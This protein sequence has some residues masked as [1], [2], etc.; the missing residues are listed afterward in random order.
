MPPSSQ[1]APLQFFSDNFLLAAGG[2]LFRLAP[3]VEQ[4]EITPSS[5][6][7]LSSLSSTSTTPT[8]DE[9]IS[10]S[11]L[12][13]P[14][15]NTPPLATLAEYE[16]T[17]AIKRLQICILR[18]STTNY[19]VLPKGRKDVKESLE[20]AAVRETFEESGFPCEL[21]PCPMSTRAPNPD[22][23]VGL[24]PHIEVASEEPFTLTIATQ[25]DGSLKLIFWYLIRVLS[26]SAPKMERTQ[27]PNEDY[28]SMFVDAREGINMLTKPD[29]Q[30]VARSAVELVE[31]A[32]AS[33]DNRPVF[34]P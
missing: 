31:S 19:F 15:S 26:N 30:K 14:T 32:M 3:T 17:D 25:K 10:G 28:D 21:L 8:S 2:V 11:Q 18:H 16:P 22:L 4:N 12:Q 9:C 13:S 24:R 5:S 20:H 29:H 33:P 1:V 7:A 23:Y 6:T 34:N 27:M